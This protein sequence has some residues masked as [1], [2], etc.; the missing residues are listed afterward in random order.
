MLCRRTSSGSWTGSG[1]CS[2]AGEYGSWLE[3]IRKGRLR[4]LFPP[5]WDSSCEYPSGMRIFRAIAAW[6]HARFGPKA[7]PKAELKTW[8]ANLQAEVPTLENGVARLK[9]RVIQREQQCAREGSASNM[10]LLDD[11]RADYEHAVR[12]RDAYLQRMEAEVRRV[13]EAL[14]EA[15]DARWKAELAR[16]GSLAGGKSYVVAPLL[17]EIQS[18]AALDSGRLRVAADLSGVTIPAAEESPQ[19]R[20]TRAEST[21]SQGG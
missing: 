20:A 1:A 17:A 18:E 12:L 16:I 15:D 14:R 2:R 11:A 21:T 4:A 7:D 3:A 5:G 13:N 8:V 9:G 19:V 6:W 10:R